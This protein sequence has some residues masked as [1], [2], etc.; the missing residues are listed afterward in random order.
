MDL[1]LGRRS[2]HTFFPMI[3][4]LKMP[5]IMMKEQPV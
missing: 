1:T 3:L 4:L 2:N 5:R